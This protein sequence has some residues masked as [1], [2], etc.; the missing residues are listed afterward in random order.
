MLA[1][2]LTGVC[3]I[4]A[5]IGAAT[6][7]WRRKIPNWLC[8]AL[9]VTAMGRVAAMGGPTMLGSAAIHAAIAFFVGMGLFAAGLIG[10]GDAKLYAASALTIPLADALAMLGWT[11]VAG[12]VIL[13][14]MFASRRVFPSRDTD[15]PTGEKMLVPYGVA[16]AIGLAVTILR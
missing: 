15:R 13:L 11:S 8:L 5:A 9:A 2:A 6:D 7:V 12:F 16:I 10:G 1:T 14:V 3:L 4:L